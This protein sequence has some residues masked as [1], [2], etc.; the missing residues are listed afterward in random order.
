MGIG[1]VALSQNE[2]IAD[3]GQP[4]PLVDLSSAEITGGRF[5]RTKPTQRIDR[6]SRASGMS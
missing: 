6:K 4:E 2:A 5:G 1:K 3:H